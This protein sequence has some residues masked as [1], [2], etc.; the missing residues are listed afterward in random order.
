MWKLIS[1][2]RR[3]CWDVRSRDFKIL[4]KHPW[5]NTVKANIGTKDTPGNAWPILET[6][7]LSIGTRDSAESRTLSPQ[8]LTRKIEYFTSEP[9][10]HDYPK[11]CLN[12][13]TNKSSA[14]IRALF[15]LR[16]WLKSIKRR[17]AFS[18]H[19]WTPRQWTSTREN[20]TPFWTRPLLTLFWYFL[21]HE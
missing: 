16:P 21:T 6:L 8:M 15:V 13:V 12:K 3:R 4:T 5:V 7:N 2:S 14:S 1:I 19:K 20:S 17:K 10:T 11:K 18:I 9:A